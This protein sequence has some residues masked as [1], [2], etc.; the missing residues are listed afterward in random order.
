M[1]LEIHLFPL[2]IR[3]IRGSRCLARLAARAC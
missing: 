3:S 2:P 1:N